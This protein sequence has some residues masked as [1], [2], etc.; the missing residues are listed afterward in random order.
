MDKEQATD[1]RQTKKGGF[2]LVELLIATTILLII[3]VMVSMVFQQQSGAFQSG[4]DKAKGQTL[5]RNAIG[6]ITRDLS[7]AVDSA[8]YPDLDQNVFNNGSS[9]TFLTVGGTPG[10]S[11]KDNDEDTS[12]VTSIQRIRFTFTGSILTREVT[13]YKATSGKLT[14]GAT[15]RTQVNGTRT[16]IN[17][18]SFEIITD[19]DAPKTFPY[20][21]KITA[22]KANDL[23]TSVITGRSAGKD[24]Q[25]DTSDD[26]LVGEKRRN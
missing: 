8:D 24:R 6:V 18:L 1:K 19:A 7:L 16:P 10:S 4:T 21:V 3:V 12:K 22:A 23:S 26:I 20:G 9:I 13:E 5:L 17:T 14:P 15:I 2:S 11:L 25:H